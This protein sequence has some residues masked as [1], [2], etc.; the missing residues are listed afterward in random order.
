MS[1]LIDT[2][3]EAGKPPAS[4]PPVAPTPGVHAELSPW[5]AEFLDY[6]A[7]ER[8]ASP[9]T[10]R[11][12][13]QALLE[14][15]SWHQGQMG[16]LPDWAALQRDVFRYYLRHLG[17]QGLQ[18][19]SIQL[20]FSSLRSFYKFLV[21][22][23]RL[24]QSPIR[25]IVPP[26]PGKRIP[27]F[28]TREQVVSLLEAPARILGTA[29]GPPRLREEAFRDRAV[30][31]TIYSCGLR[32]AE[33]CSLQADQIQWAD[34]LV[35][36]IGKGRKERQL[37]I[38]RPALEAIKSYWSLL[39]FV[40]SGTMPAFYTTAKDPK[41]VYPR[42]V[43]SGLKKYLAFCGLDARITPHKLRH[44][45]A[46]HILDAG[47]DLRSVQELLGHAHLSTTQIYTHV[48]L[49]RLRKVYRDAHPRARGDTR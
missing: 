40:P 28:L 15:Q 49:E 32:V 2:K 17:R 36:V 31:E 45:Y 26:Q 18:R 16:A 23:G 12:Y 3:L 38:G 48:T 9:C 35:R 27:V 13:G 6:L 30:L 29:P 8:A 1:A 39:P 33:L 24:E 14:F 37:P 22:R 7:V 11:N 4:A 46:T 25:D 41:P 21:R 44:S 19:A 5:A 42:L 10:R 43:Q 47:A 20:R 34:S